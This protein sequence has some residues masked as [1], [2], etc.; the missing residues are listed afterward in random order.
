[1]LI[2]LAERGLIPDPLLRFGMRR[3]MGARLRTER[4]DGGETQF[5]RYQSR[6]AELREGPV[7]LH[8]DAA[9]DQHY[10]VPAAFFER[11]LGR[12]LKYSCALWPPGTE[13]L[14]EA[15]AAMLEVT[16]HRAGLADGQRILELG[17]GWGSLSLWM[18]GRYPGSR[19]TAVSNS[20]SQ[21]E[22]IEARARA[23]GVVN[24]EVVTADM[25]VFETSER[26]DRV[27]S[28][29]MF[30]HMHNYRELLR[31]VST[32]LN[33]DGRLFVHV[34]C[35]REFLYPFETEGR[36]DWMAEHFFT[37][38]IMPAEQMFPWFQEHLRLEAQ[39]RV[40]GMHYARTSNAWLARMDAAEDEILRIFSEVYGAADARRWVQRWRMFFMAVAELF[41]YAG[42]HE[43]FV[44]HALFTQ[45]EI[46][47]A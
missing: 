37:G 27:V 40:N 13:S 41:G 44:T 43:W 16:C 31:R 46:A 6:L 39:W 21:R 32:W 4:G 10:E 20:A 28:I 15:E 25:N 22:F 35:H 36:Y 23:A 42:G 5:A 29:E 17:C 18:A 1:M 26:F 12:Y 47:E 24:L 30:E 38:G 33:A 7:A 8:T 45:R 9:N 34:F 2:E 14:D 3:L 11:V 19:I